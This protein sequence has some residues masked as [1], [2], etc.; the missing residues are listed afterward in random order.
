AAQIAERP[1]PIQGRLGNHWRSFH[2]ELTEKINELERLRDTLSSCI[3]CGCLSMTACA[4]Y[5]PEDQAYRHGPGPR[6]LM[7]NA[8]HN[9]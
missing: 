9:I 1:H 2:S 7:G 4:L 5:N 3:G 6:Y 8:P